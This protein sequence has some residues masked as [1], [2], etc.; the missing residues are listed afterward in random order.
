MSHIVVITF[1]DPDEAG[2]VREALRSVQHA[3]RLSLDDSAVVVQDAEGKTHVKNE[4]DRG[5][6]IGAVGGGLL[7]LLIA[8]LFFPVVGLVI[9]AV[10]GG[11]I[12]K[13]VEP[14]VDRK[15][16]DDVRADLEP[17]SSAIFFIVRDAD[18]DVAVAAQRPYKGN[19]YHTS[20]SDEDE[21]ELRRVLSKEI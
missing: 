4:I 15:F 9:G 21:K 12:G 5:V 14:G 2:K 20:F 11:I 8:G 7:G 19:V 18:P 1:D 3:G 16:I 17:E 13:A 10:T 6:G